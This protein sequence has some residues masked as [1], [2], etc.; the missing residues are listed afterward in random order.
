ML[1]LPHWLYFSDPEAPSIFYA[2]DGVSIC[3]DMPLA[4]LK[5]I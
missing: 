2:V 1:S 4:W 5:N 3:G